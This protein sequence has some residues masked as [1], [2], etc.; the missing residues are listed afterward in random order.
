MTG[1]TACTAGLLAGPLA[2]D[3]WCGSSEWA[4]S[5]SAVDSVNA[6]ISDISFPDRIDVFISHTPLQRHGGFAWAG[7]RAD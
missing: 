3:P 4:G 7:I 6:V 1:L 2:S 5:V